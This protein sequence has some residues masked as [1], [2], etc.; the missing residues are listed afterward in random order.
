MP[1]R[2]KLHFL[3]TNDDGVQAEGL[4]HL[5][6]VLR[7]YGRVTVIAPDR[8]RSGVSHGF[9]LNHPLLLNRHGGEVYSL[10]GTPADCIMFGIRG[11]LTGKDAPDYIFSGINH[12]ANLGADVVYSGT[13]AGAREGTIFCKPSVAVSLA[14]EFSARFD[15]QH[16]HFETVQRFL[17]AFIPH[18]LERG[19]PAE[20]FL[21]INVPNIPLDLFK[22]GRFTRIGKRIYRDQF[23]R[24]VDDQGH[25]YYW[26]GGEP[27]T[28]TP[29]AGSDFEAL[30]ASMASITPLRWMSSNHSDLDFTRQWP[31]FD[32]N[33]SQD[34]PIHLE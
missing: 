4:H 3:V 20:V 17:H 7:R 24:K 27:P 15:S 22:G 23:I 33:H 13:A 28:H 25:E 8:E 10:S 9:S 2:R 18:F 31:S 14:T 16:F 29:E 12:G 11:F 30:E 26:L 6:E 1:A 34:P 19:L 32:W 21:N 5:A